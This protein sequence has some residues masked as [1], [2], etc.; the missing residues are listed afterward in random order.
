[1][2]HGLV[3]ADKSLAVIEMACINIRCS[4]ML[5]ENFSSSM[6]ID[7]LAL[8]GKN[9][10]RSVAKMQCLISPS[11][12]LY[13]LLFNLANILCPSYKRREQSLELKVTRKWQAQ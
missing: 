9:N 3:D 2:S 7:S 13:S 4:K 12:C 6:S 10:A 11:T 8:F 1:M 5:Q